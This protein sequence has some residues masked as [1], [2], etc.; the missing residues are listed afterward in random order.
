VVVQATDAACEGGR[1]RA[2]RLI[3]PLHAVVPE[4]RS[5]NARF[6]HLRWASKLCGEGLISSELSFVD[7]STESL[8]FVGEDPKARD[9][10]IVKRV[11]QDFTSSHQVQYLLRNRIMVQ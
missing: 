2:V 10:S 8:A 9:A 11:P 3:R 4:R 6:S 7:P 5:R 1:A